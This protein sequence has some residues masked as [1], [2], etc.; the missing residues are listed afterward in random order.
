MEISCGI[1]I[2]N[3][4]KEILIKNSSYGAVVALKYNYL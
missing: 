2:F 3:E 4:K 1:I